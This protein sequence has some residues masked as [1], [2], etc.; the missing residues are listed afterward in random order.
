MLWR[1][2]ILSFYGL[3]SLFT[4][5]FFLICYIPVT[6][7]NVNYQIRY[8]IAVIFSCAF[9]WLAKICCG[10]K[11]EVE[12]LEKLPKT[13]SI[14]VSNHQSFW[15]QMFMQLIIP[16]H[17]WV[18]KRELF[19]IPLLGW[20]LRMVKPIAVNRGTN[21]SVAQILRE[22]EEKIKEGLWLIIFPESTKVLPDRTVKFKPSAVKLASITKVPIVMMAHNAGLFWPRGFWFK[23]PGTIKVKIIGVIEREEVEQTEVRILN[24]KIEEIINSEK[25]KLLN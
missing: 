25:Q 7:F 6:F 9:V 12:G 11:Y 5:I 3:L 18:L 20:G 16:K 4:F 8:R 15:D 14:V 17:S 21:S 24:D 2:R 1:L 23:Q 22:G 13:I 19:N 10:L